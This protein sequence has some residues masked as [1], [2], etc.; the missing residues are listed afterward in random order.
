MNPYAM[1]SQNRMMMN[2]QM[3]QQRARR[4]LIEL[5]G[6][7]MYNY[8]YDYA[9]E[10][11]DDDAEYDY[12][13]DQDRYEEAYDEQMS[14]M[15]AANDEFIR[16]LRDELSNVALSFA[17][18]EHWDDISHVHDEDHNRL[19]RKCSTFQ[20]ARLCATTD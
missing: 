17:D 1:Q 13:L 7:E 19:L 14:Q 8:G 4:R 10:Y 3:M 15:D 6:D 2:P 16:V 12:D 18:D 20:T 9:A 5:E 11:D